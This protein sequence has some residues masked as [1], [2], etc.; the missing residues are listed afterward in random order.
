MP[1]AILLQSFE[2][3]EADELS[4]SK[5]EKVRILTEIDDTWYASTPVDVWSLV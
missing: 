5:G 1:K 2:G 4:C 3:A